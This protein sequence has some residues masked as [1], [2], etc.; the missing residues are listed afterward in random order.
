MGRLI[1]AFA[2]FVIAT[3]MIAT[4]HAVLLEAFKGNQGFMVLAAVFWIVVVGG[5]CLSDYRKRQAK[6]D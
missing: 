2:V 3:A 6:L 4:F 1:G 5:V